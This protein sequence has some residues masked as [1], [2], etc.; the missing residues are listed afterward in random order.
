[1][2]LSTHKLL[3]Q[4]SFTPPEKPSRSRSRSRSRE[5]ALPQLRPPVPAP[6]KIDRE[7][8]RWPADGLTATLHAGEADGPG[9]QCRVL[10]VSARGARV[11]AAEPMREGDAIVLR[12]NVDHYLFGR[13]VNAQVVYAFAHDGE[14]I[15]GCA[16]CEP[17]G[18]DGCGVIVPTTGC[19]RRFGRYLCNFPSACR[20]MIAADSDW[21]AS[22]INVSQGGICLANARRIEVGALLHID[23]D[24]VE[25]T[26]RRSMIGKVVHLH[27]DGRRFV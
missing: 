18:E 2:E 21:T 6:P 23:L 15:L 8:F 14:W 12:I 17:T 9:Q 10:D 20:A 27:A 24:A 3:G 5:R 26:A 11:R 1:M 13:P 16:F 4:T 25:A 7:P 19:R 22:V